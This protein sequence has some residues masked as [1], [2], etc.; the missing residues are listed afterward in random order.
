MGDVRRAT[1]S[2][3]LRNPEAPDASPRGPING[4]VGGS[5]LRVLDSDEKNHRRQE[6][7]AKRKQEYEKYLRSATWQLI[8]RR[9][10]ARENFVCQGCKQQ[11]TVVHHIRYP[12]K[13]GKEKLEWL[14]ALCAP[15][16]EKIHRLAADGLTLRRATRHVLGLE[17][18]PRKKKRTRQQQRQKRQRQRGPKLKL[19]H[20]GRRVKNPELAAENDRLHQLQA[21]N[22]ERRAVH[23]RVDLSDLLERRGM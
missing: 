1:E 8:R 17:L 11:A 22:R 10:L 13:L 19:K 18:L 12:A 3:A 7:R 2:D 15:C 23:Q 20:S 21:R 16:H 14:Y 5:V 6:R 9:V 4:G